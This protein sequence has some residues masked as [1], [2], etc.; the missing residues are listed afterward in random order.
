MLQTEVRL[1]T[2]SQQF[3]VIKQANNLLIS[4]LIPKMEKNIFRIKELVQVVRIRKYFSSF[5]I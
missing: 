2:H 5:R 1:F 3:G 4:E